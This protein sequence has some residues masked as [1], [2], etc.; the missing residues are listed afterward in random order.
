MAIH[1]FSFTRDFSRLAKV[2]VTKI[3]ASQR[4]EQG[5]KL[6][7]NEHNLALS[8]A[9]WLPKIGSMSFRDAMEKS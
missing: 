9:L 6:P 1:E 4:E 8:R 5:Q 2:V 3:I 7:Q